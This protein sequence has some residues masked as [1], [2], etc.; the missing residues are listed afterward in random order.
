MTKEERKPIRRELL[1]E[2]LADYK[3]PDDL[4]GESGLLK[5]LTRALVNRAMQAEISEHLGYDHGKAPP[6]GQANRRNGKRGKRLR[7]DQGM[8]DVEVPR[9]RDGT[10]EPALVPKHAREFRGFDDKIIAMYARGM[11]VRDIQAHLTDLY[12]IDVSRDLISRVT[13][14]VVEELRA[15]QQRPLEEVY[16]IVYI[17]ALVVKIRHKGVV[18]N[19]A[20]HVAVGVRVDGRKEVL[21][22][23]IAATEGAKFWLAILTELQQ[24]GVR[25][26]FVLCADGLKGLPEAVEASFPETIFQTCIVHLIRS[27]TRYV[28]WSE[29]RGLC[30]E[31]R[32][33]YTAAD[34]EAAMVAF[35]Q[36]EAAHGDKYPTVVKAWRDR[37]EEWT[38]FL[39]FPQ[40]IRRIIYT[41][42]A[43]EALHRQL[44]KVLKT[45]GHLPSDDAAL[46]L[47]FLAVRNAESSWGGRTRSWSKALMQFAIHFEGRLP[48]L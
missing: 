24:R 48:Q 21:G 40:E 28:T 29:R 8:L 16:P 47:L 33:L 25:D 10:F 12:G 3:S 26:I 35:E 17:D 2:L 9:D 38:P 1:D 43:I 19:R 20:V 44:R 23:W 7:S 13:D 39:T 5:E 36:F 41:T 45:R 32:K 30:A 37:W 4:I 46:K 11:T 18:Q 14:E 31:L 27:S 22:M 34:E 42:N 15:W 6:D